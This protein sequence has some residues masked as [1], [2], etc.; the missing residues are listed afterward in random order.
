MP[1]P[2]GILLSS[3]LVSAETTSESWRLFGKSDIVS[4]KLGKLIY[5]EYLGIPHVNIDDLPVMR[6]HHVRKDFDRFLPK[7]VMV[8]VG[9]KEALRDDILDFS[10]AVEEDGKHNIQLFQE[11]YAHD[12]FM[13][14]EIVK[15]KDKKM[16]EKYDEMFVDFVVRAVEEAK[17][18]ESSRE[19]S[20]IK[21]TVDYRLSGKIISV[22]ILDEQPVIDNK[23]DGP[24]VLLDKSSFPK[25]S[26]YKPNTIL[27]EYSVVTDSVPPTATT[28]IAT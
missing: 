22:K 2:A 8:F 9:E 17:S 15:K 20:I 4:T 11:H 21:E 27:S 26:V 24:L 5:K 19:N 7:N 28:A 10:K 16:I 14:R 13:I 3:P 23:Y 18:A 1:L 12:W 25:P 6:L